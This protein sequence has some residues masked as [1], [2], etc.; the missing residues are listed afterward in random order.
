MCITVSV[1]SSSCRINRRPRFVR[2]D[3]QYVRNSIPVGPVALKSQQFRVCHA[4]FS[5]DVKQ[6]VNLGY[7]TTF[8]GFT[9]LF[10]LSS[11]SMLWFKGLDKANTA[12]RRGQSG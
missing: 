3:Y 12:A 10:L 1:I 7:S 2:Y 6:Y 11:W 4:T 8:D 9:Y 5:K